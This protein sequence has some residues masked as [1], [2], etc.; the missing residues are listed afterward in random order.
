MEPATETGPS[1]IKQA[2]AVLDMCALHQV[3]LQERVLSGEEKPAPPAPGL[4][5]PDPDVTEQPITCLATEF[6]QRA[7]AS[8]LGQAAYIL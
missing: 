2:R 3:Q 7:A 4:P 6:V 1:L 8:Y 5:T